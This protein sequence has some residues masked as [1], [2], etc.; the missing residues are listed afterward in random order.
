M[1]AFYD[2]KPSNIEAVG[3][4]SFLYR[5]DIAEVIPEIT[6]GD[7]NEEQ[8]SQWQCQEVTVWPPLSSDRVIAEVIRSKYS[9]EQ[10]LS[11]MNK[12]NAYQQGLDVTPDIVDEYTD[13][14]AFVAQVKRNV[15][16][17]LGEE[18]EVVTKAILTPRLYDLVSVVAMTV[19]TMDISDEDALRVKYV[20]PLWDTLIGKTVKA[21]FKILSD[22]RLWKVRQDHTVQ[23]QYKPGTGTESL[24]AEIVESSAGTKDDPIPYNNNMELEKGKFYTQ[25]GIIY[26]CVRDTGS[27]VFNPLADLVGIYVEVVQT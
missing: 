19:N 24:Y 16:K 1:Q 7:A 9:T 2:N 20:Y 25:N 18:T 8:T 10:E 21:G 14:L 22:N 3:N 26:E 4:G 17:D 12:F 5:W 11:L 13:Y 27:P 23:E 6:E 15:R